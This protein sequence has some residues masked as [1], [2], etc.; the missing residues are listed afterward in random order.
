[1]TLFLAAGA[2]TPLILALIALLVVVQWPLS[3]LALV[4]LFA[5][6]PGKK[7]AVLWNIFIVAGVIVGPVIFL[8]RSAVKKRRA[9]SSS[10]Q[11]PPSAP[12]N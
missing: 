10:C 5:E 3:M 4:R 7:G 12:E 1:M 6:K 2:N 9:R 11:E 8:I